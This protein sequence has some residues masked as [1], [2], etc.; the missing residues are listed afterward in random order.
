[1]EQTIHANVATLREEIAAVIAEIEWTANSLVPKDEVKQRILAG[2]KAMGENFNLRLAG[3]ANPENWQQSLAD[4]LTLH[5]SPVPMGGFMAAT[6][7]DEF[8][9]ALSKK[10]DGLKYSP[11]PA[12][13]ERP[14]LLKNLRARLRELERR[15]EALIVQAEADG[16]VIAR[17]ADADPAVVLSFDPG[18]EMP[19]LELARRFPR[20]AVINDS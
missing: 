13:Q 19:Q 7:G 6:M 11:G 10:I 4:M 1:M 3:V 12:T 17:R 2:C 5:E 8:A 15:E 18:G 20:A 16:V 14:E 9:K